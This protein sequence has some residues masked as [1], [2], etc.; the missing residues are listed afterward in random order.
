MRDVDSLLDVLIIFV[1]IFS[2]VQYVVAINK[3]KAFHL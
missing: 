2:I 1:E 3:R